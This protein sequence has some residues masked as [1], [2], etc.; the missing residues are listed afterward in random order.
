MRVACEFQSRRILRQLD[1]EYPRTLRIGGELHLRGHVQDI[2]KEMAYCF[3]ATNFGTPQKTQNEILP[4]QQHEKNS[5]PLHDSTVP[6]AYHK[7]EMVFCDG[8]LHKSSLLP[9]EYRTRL[10]SQ[11]TISF[12]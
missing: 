10:P 3:K 7:K 9:Y 8:D 6:M 11:N 2:P 12:L 1:G 5:I 4:A